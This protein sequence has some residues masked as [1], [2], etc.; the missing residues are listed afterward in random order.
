VLPCH[1]IL[2]K[3][4][5]KDDDE[6]DDDSNNYY[7]EDLSKKALSNS[8]SSSKIPI[9]SRSILVA[10]PILK[11]TPILDPTQNYSAFFG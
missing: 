2:C 6:D 3:L 4:L 5:L 7:M 11:M 9:W 10:K 1:T 8:L